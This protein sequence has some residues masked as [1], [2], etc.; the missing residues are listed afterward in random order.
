MA[1]EKIY[2]FGKLPKT[3]M[4]GLLQQICSGTIQTFTNHGGFAILG[5][6][7]AILG[8]IFTINF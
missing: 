3:L 4:D 5:K 7:F 6:I 1:P 8:K 2:V